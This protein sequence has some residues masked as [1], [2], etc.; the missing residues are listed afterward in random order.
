[1]GI[2]WAN[3]LQ[4]IILVYFTHQKKTEVSHIENELILSTMCER[5]SLKNFEQE[6][7]GEPGFIEPLP[8]YLLCIQVFQIPSRQI[9]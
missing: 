1:M 6:F 8:K 5:S 2:K 7:P 4:S 9:A 3:I